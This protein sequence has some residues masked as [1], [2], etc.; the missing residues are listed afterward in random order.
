MPFRAQDWNWMMVL[1]PVFE[2]CLPEGFVFEA[3]RRH[4]QKR[5]G[6]A[7]SFAFLKYFA[8]GNRGRLE[9]SCSDPDCETRVPQ[10]FSSEEALSF[11]G[12]LDF[13][14]LAERCLST[15]FVSGEQP[16]VLAILTEGAGS[17]EYII[18]A[19]DRTEPRLAENEYFCMRAAE[20]AGIPVP[21]FRI[22]EDACLYATRRF[23]LEE[24][25]RRLGFEDLCVLQGK[26]R[27]DK[28]LGSYEEAART[29]ALFVSPEK[30]QQSLSL[31][32][33]MLCVSVLVRNGNAHLKNF[34]V[35]Y[36][37][38]LQDRY[39]APA[40]DIVTT[41]A[42]LPADGMALSMGGRKSWPGRR[43]LVDF[44]AGSCML[45]STEALRLFEECATAVAATG[46]ELE[47]YMAANPEF[48]ETGGRMLSSWSAGLSGERQ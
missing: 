26:N 34:G 3:L 40:Y 46:S 36:S 29:V 15:T 14:V 39:L 27:V 5:F 11:K 7:D 32:Y 33:R 17:G 22:S 37:P 10:S 4:V 42:Y 2:M 28:Y 18:K 16:K 6:A 24:G 25:G 38:D 47:E 35:L 31:L 13:D 43:R 30:R 23:D 21:E 20:R 1:H 9:Y 19:W 45:S 12:G 41:T 44:G 48:R 8:N